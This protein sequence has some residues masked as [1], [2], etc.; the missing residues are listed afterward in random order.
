M[1]A[2]SDFKELLALLNA[3]NVEYVIVGAPAR[4]G[5]PAAHHR[6]R[7]ALGGIRERWWCCLRSS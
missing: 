2:K 4:G 1:E 7:T 3:H 5:N 6:L